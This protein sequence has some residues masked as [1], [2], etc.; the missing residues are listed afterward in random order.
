M[1]KRDNIFSV[2]KDP[3]VKFTFDKHV[4]D[5]FPD[6]IE[7]SVPGYSTTIAM[8]GVI[9]NQYAQKSSN[10]YD[11]GSSL[12]AAT[13]AMRHHIKAEDIKIIAVDNSEAMVKKSQKIIARDAGSIP[14]ELI[15][16]D[17]RN[18]EINNASVVVLNFTLQFLQLAERERVIQQ[19]YNGLNPGGVLLLSEKILFADH[20]INERQSNWHH[21]YKRANGYSELEV[22]QKRTALENVLIPE[23]MDANITRLKKCGFT[24]IDTWF[25]CFNFFSMVAK[26]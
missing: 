14:I 23:T 4:A 3:L 24:Q 15:H 21:A 2:P 18:T 6:M 11:L 25:Q 7:R 22:A 1:I 16:G 19:I 26:K 10:C 17:I 12:G 13:L 9:A 5:V 8:I 20:T